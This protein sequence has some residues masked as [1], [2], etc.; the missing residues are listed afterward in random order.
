MSRGDRIIRAIIDEALDEVGADTVERVK[1]EIF[2]H[3]LLATRQVVRAFVK[4]HPGVELARVPV[5]EL[6]RW[7][8]ENAHE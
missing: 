3:M 5:T 4:A 6:L 1:G 2:R 7:A 8:A